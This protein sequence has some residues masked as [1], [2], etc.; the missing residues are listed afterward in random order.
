MSSFTPSV[1]AAWPPV[2]ASAERSAGE[3]WRAGGL[4]LGAVLLA[5]L[6]VLWGLLQLEGARPAVLATAT[7]QVNLLTSD[8]VPPPQAA[9]PSPPVTTPPRPPAPVPPAR[10]TVIAVPAPPQAETQPTLAPP[11]PEA[12]VSPEPAPPAPAPEASMPVPPAPPA[13]QPRLIA[14]SDIVCPTPATVDYPPVSEQL[15]EQ[16][17]ALVRVLIDAQGRPRD[18]A[19]HQTSGHPRLDRAALAGV[20]SLRCQ[21]YTEAGVAQAVWVL[22][23]IEFRF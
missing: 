15:G 1:L 7:L 6:G 16:G 3:A 14:A 12:Q 21:P 9:P 2:I 22:A 23:P 11:E 5:H 19:L 13:P 10:K 20:R 17:T 8:P 18:A 4:S